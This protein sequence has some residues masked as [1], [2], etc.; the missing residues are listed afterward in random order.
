MGM[1]KPK[2]VTVKPV[3]EMTRRDLEDVVE[4]VRAQVWW[5]DDND[6]WD[7]NLSGKLLDETLAARLGY[8]AGI[9]EE[10]GL[11]PEEK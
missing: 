3:W 11:G 5:D 1:K 2:E 6:R 9:L 10:H 8:V 4:R 7:Q